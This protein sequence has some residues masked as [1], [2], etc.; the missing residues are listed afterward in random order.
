MAGYQNT[1]SYEDGGGYVLCQR[2]GYKVRR[3][4]TVIEPRSKLRVHKDWAD[5]EHPQDH[6]RA[7]KDKQNF[8][9]NV[10][11]PKDKFLRCNQVTEDD[12]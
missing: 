11:E 12:F 3:K 9:G 8:K 2:S 6:K 4:D 7:L 1:N 10:P 5:P